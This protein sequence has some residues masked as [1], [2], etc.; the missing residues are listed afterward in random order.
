MSKGYT[1]PAGLDL[2]TFPPE[3]LEAFAAHLELHGSLPQVGDATTFDAL[4]AKTVEALAEALDEIQC[5]EARENPAAFVQYCFRHEETDAPLMNAEHHNEWHEF[6]NDN[7][8]AILFAPV[9]HA[10][11]QHIA[12]GRVLYALGKN[13]SKR[14]AVVSL[15]QSRHADK[16]V[17][18]V[19][20]HIESNPRLHKV[21]P[22]LKPSE[23]LHDP[24]GQSRIVVQRDTNA[25]DPS[26]QG[27]GA[28]GPINGSRLDGII[29]D[30]VLNFEN[31]RTADQITKLIEWMDSEVFTRVG[32]DGWIHWIGTPWTPMDPMHQV[33]KRSGWASER[34]SAVLNPDA[35]M[36]DWEPMWPEQFSIDRLKRIYHATTPLNFA[37]KYLCQVRMDAASRFK[38]EW[39]DNALGLGRRM[40]LTKRHPVGPS[41]QALR[42]YTG[43]DL[44]VGQKESND[45]TC[46][47][48]IAVEENGRK[49]VLDIQ[50]GR[51]TAPEIL[52]RIQGVVQ[53][54]GSIVYVE[55]VAAQSFLLQWASSQGLPVRGFTT[56]AG[57]KYHEHYGVESLAI[58]M[59]NG[60][61][62]IPS[63]EPGEQIDPEVDEWIREMLY[64]TPEA[65]T[66]DRLMASWFAREAARAGGAPIF[67]H[68][69]TLAR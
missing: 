6:L 36:E 58:E 29:I 17:G 44:G 31:T 32:D 55:D 25:K 52:Q 19:R 48:T 68:V 4:D 2:A 62:V 1:L 3:A 69:D 10:K 39:I 46:L 27:L 53:N 18:Q 12:V 14:L 50:S 16:V 56:T 37:R 61:W 23:D 64:Y 49:R 11:T 8:R 20:R 15:T 40:R 57:K 5:Q 34:Y 67:Q 66:G 43:V 42:C 9:E 59:R 24:W 26:L 33:A 35:P 65:H 60:G 21:F 63:G 28:F 22:D 7:D 51:F 45:L 13:P 30:D 47:F 54:Y 41:G 38:Q